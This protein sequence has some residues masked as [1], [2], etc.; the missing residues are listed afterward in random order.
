MKKALWLS[1]FSIILLLTIG[2]NQR[3]GKPRLLVFT[4]AAGYHHDSI[5]IGVPTLLSLGNQHNFEIDTTSDIGRFREDS[6]KKYS[7]VIFLNTS[8][9]LLDHFHRADFERYI[10]AGGGY[11]GIHATPAAKY[12][13]GWYGRL[14]TGTDSTGRHEFDGGRAWYTPS[15][16]TDA[17]FADSAW[18]G[19]LLGGIEYAI[20][21]NK[22]LDYSKATSLRAPEEDR[23]TK[24]PVMM[25]E[26]FE[27][28][29]MTILPNLD[30]L[31]AQR[32]GEIMLYKSATKTVKQV[33]FLDV[34]WKTQHTPGVNAE[35]G[36]L[37]IQKDPDFNTNHFVYI[38]YSPSDTSV[39]RLSRFTFTNDSIDK[40]SEKI[41]LQLYSQR[42]I[43]CHTGG[44]IA[45]GQDNMLFVSTGDNSTP[46][47]EPNTP[48]PSHGYAPLDD[49]PGH[50]QY[51]SRRGAGNTNDLRG[52]ILRIKLKPDGSYEI[53]DGNLFPKGEPKTRP[54]IYVM[55]DRNPY[56]IS[57]D[58]KNG[59]L[60]WGEVGPDANQDSLDTRGP[61]GY[62]EVNQARKAGFFGWPYFVGDNYAYHIHDYATN[63][64]GAAFDPAHPVN[65]SRNNTGLRDLP[66]AQPAFVWYPYAESPDF[67][68]VGSG[69]RC[70]M[71]GPVFYS[72]LYPKET[73]MPDYY[74]G[75]FFMYDFTRCWFKAV[76]LLPNGDFDK[77]EPFMEHT[78]F[79]S[80]IDVEMGPD[81]KLYILEYGTGWFSKNADAGISR[82]DFNS[83]N[84]PPKISDLT[85]DKTSGD[86]PLN[87]KVTVDAKDPEND[88]L[89]YIWD[90]GNGVKKETD[91]PVLETTLTTAGDYA[92]SVEVKDDK[93]EPAISSKVNVYA[94]NEAP[95]VRIELKGNKTFYFPGTP[96]AYQVDIEDK[97][98]TAKVKDLND[99]IVSA[100]YMEGSDKAATPQ[101]HQ[102]LSAA[103]MGKNLML[104]LDCKTCHKVNE[105][106]IGPSFQ[107]VADRYQKD[108]DMVS[109]LVQKI[110]KGGSGKW[111]E[112]VMPAH[113]ALKEEDVR[114][115][116][117]WIQTLSGTNKT[118][119]SLPASGTV[120]PTL[121]KPEKDKGILTISASYTDKGGNNIKPLTGSHSVSLRNAKIFLGHRK[122]QQ[123]NYST[124]SIDLSTVRSA[125]LMTNNAKG[126]VEAGSFELR[127]DSPVGQLIGS[128]TLKGEEK[129]KIS[130]SLEPAKDGKLHKLFIVSHPGKTGGEQITLSLLQLNNK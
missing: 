24:S 104:S 82:I 6:L 35:E 121:D 33:G 7:A 14:I 10:Q 106:S 36:L 84:R 55:G 105:K 58:W 54:E 69:G 65:D 59:Y 101:G 123:G 45:F 81:G 4:K 78:K 8:G 117:G 29:E 5:P 17:S 119:K 108:P 28:T 25:G 112:V 56:R 97:D 1:Y 38:Y 96:V 124:D 44:S 128:F 103:T 126:P 42:E 77:M 95:V 129:E 37:G 40:K 43:C 74:N 130:T 89:R 62:D 60:Y 83:G 57:V 122:D 48:Y 92:I 76:T 64:N 19:Q 39:N 3:S 27:P 50:L 31:V 115:I 73:R 16:D 52:K 46:F 30:I 79:N 26:F 11:V 107:D 87:I 91:G 98:D 111:G 12:D 80:P 110:T 102:T 100:D 116:I 67:P 15:G 125:S 22:N 109:W 9:T 127:L 88:K 53:P 120:H 86:L 70:A 99:L 13:W 72:D 20:G 94:G 63:V 75:K 118:I 32:R 34:Y 21:D 113:P 61:R 93:S 18:V 2:C 71:A 41:I 66:P 23:F 90:L 68:Q 51:D 114:Q 85:I 49:R 47:D